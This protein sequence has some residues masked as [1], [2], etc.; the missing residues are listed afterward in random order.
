MARWTPLILSLVRSSSFSEEDLQQHASFLHQT[1]ESGGT[2][3][4]HFA[5]LRKDVRYTQ[6]L[7]QQGADVNKVNLYQESPLHW[8]VK[9]G[10]EDVVKVLLS[11]GALLNATDA[12]SHS[13]LDWARDEN[14]THL[15]PLLRSL[16]HTRGRSLPSLTS[17]FR[18][19]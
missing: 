16:S 4:L 13:P 5:V 18:I 10:H 12:D 6:F 8:A 17:F 3:P 15:I 11:A 1:T 19:N 7:L 14:Q 9:A 2:S